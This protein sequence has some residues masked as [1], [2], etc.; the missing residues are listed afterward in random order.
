VAG[1][2]KAAT[3]APGVF[4][5]LFAVADETT[6]DGRAMIHVAPRDRS[7]ER[8]RLVLGENRKTVRQIEIDWRGGRATAHLR[9]FQV[10]APAHEGLFRPDDASN[11]Q[12]VSTAD[13]LGIFRAATDFGM[14]Q[15]GG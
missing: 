6:E 15:L 3:L 5:Q 14:H 1:A 4:E 11:R 9:A 7:S 2:L 8:L 13:L 12:E 10:N